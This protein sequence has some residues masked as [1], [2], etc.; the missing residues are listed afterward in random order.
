[1]GR[2]LQRNTERQRKV[3][4]PLKEIS[5]RSTKATKMSLHQQEPM[6]IK[7]SRDSKTTNV[8]AYTDG[9][10]AELLKTARASFNRIF[11]QILTNIWSSEKMP[12]EMNLSI[13]C[14]VFKTGNRSEL[15]NYRGISL[16]NVSYKILA[17]IIA[18]RL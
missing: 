11:H 2:F 13:I 15:K 7:L 16:L 6:W 8:H 9:I 18:E 4:H 14:P 1:M 3:E 5:T 17:S 12:Q 10:P